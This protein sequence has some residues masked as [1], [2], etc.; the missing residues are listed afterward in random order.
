MVRIS[1]PLDLFILTELIKLTHRFDT[2]VLL[3]TSRLHLMTS[4]LDSI[5]RSVGVDR[6]LKHPDMLFSSQLA[7]SKLPST[8]RFLHDLIDL[9]LH[10]VILLKQIPKLN[11]L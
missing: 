11:G 3:D 5:T 7:S 4:D 6:I 8:N 2:Q 10:L 9:H 1:L